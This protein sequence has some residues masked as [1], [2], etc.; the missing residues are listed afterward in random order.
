MSA[1]NWK[2][3]SETTVH[4]NGYWEYRI[5]KFL[6]EDGTGDEYHYVHTSGS[7]MIIPVTSGGNFLLV[8]QFRYLNA[9]E[10]LEFP[11]GGIDHGLSPEENAIKELREETG[12]SARKLE[13]VG[14]FSPFTGACDE[15]C[16][17]YVATGLYESPLPKDKSEEG[18]K[19]ISMNYNELQNLIDNNKIWDGLTL[20]AWAL[21]HKKL[22]KMLVEK[23]NILNFCLL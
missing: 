17:V 18:M 7:T 4:N 14:S 6:H 19:V 3:I 20:A 11:C 12:Y 21:F 10:S 5:D 8:S 22:Q 9:K 13:F 15:I 16:N 23:W 1:K 2:K